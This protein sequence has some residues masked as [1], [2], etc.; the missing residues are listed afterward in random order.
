MK[1]SGLRRLAVVGALAAGL[2]L[3]LSMMPG[4]SLG[5]PT[6]EQEAYFK[7]AE[8]WAERS[9]RAFGELRTI[10]LEGGDRPELVLDEGYRR[11][12]KR[13]LDESTSNHQAM[14]DVDVSPGAEEVHSAVVR[15]VRTFIE[16]NELLWQGVMD[17]DVETMQRGG[18]KLIEGT[19]LLEEATAMVKRFCE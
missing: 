10:L 17:V 9:G 8:E 15:A 13:I 4:C 6:P 18:E 14:I 1:I 3:A 19:R 2:L 12:L 5:C 16:A 11:R 7:K